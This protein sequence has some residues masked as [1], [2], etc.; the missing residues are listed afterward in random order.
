MI[1]SFTSQYPEDYLHCQQ[2][3]RSENPKHTTPILFVYYS[4]LNIHP[5]SYL[6]SY[7][8]SPFLPPVPK[9]RVANIACNWVCSGLR[10][11][12]SSRRLGRDG[13]HGE[14]KLAELAW[15]RSSPSVLCGV[16]T[17]V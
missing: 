6:L 5:L 17:V 12:K 15:V 14:E 2:T 9:T 4:S 11:G 7:P 13:V 8:L 3:L 16:V 10:L 1:S